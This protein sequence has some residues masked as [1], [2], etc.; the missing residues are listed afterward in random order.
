MTPRLHLFEF[1]DRPRVLREAET[2]YVV[3]ACRPAVKRSS[4][5]S[6]FSCQLAM[7]VGDGLTVQ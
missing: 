5:L 1:N 7:S 4:Q 3:T 6:A 2:V